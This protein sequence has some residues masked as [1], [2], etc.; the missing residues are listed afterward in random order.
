MA[1]F[2]LLQRSTKGEPLS[3]DL[4]H[5]V[6]T[7]TLFGPDPTATWEAIM[8]STLTEDGLYL[9]FDSNCATCQGISSRVQ[10]SAKGRLVAKPLN[11]PD[12]IDARRE[13]FGDEPPHKPTLMRVRNGD[14]Q[15]WTG[16]SMGWILTKELGTRD[17]LAIIQALGIERQSG[18]RT[19]IRPAVEKKL[20]RRKFGQV[21]AGLA[22]AMSVFA[23]G[24]LT[25]AAFAKVPQK[26]ET[27][28]SCR[29]AKPS[30]C[31]RRL[32]LPRTC[33]ASPLQ[34]LSTGSRAARLPIVTAS[35]SRAGSLRCPIQGRPILEMALSFQ[36]TASSLCFRRS[37]T[38]MG[39][40]AELSQS[41][42]ARLD[43]SHTLPK[44]SAIGMPR[45]LS[46]LKLT[47][48]P[49]E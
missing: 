14:I 2:K 16:P 24:S 46:S 9:A 43:Y 48:N 42:S 21:A 26:L 41:D 13:I 47:R 18:H 33:A 36:E 27:T 12:V 22:A 8:P 17:T 31:S 37:R 3:L 34:A 11:D 15:A 7:A 4:R 32:L 29:I 10:Q 28:S 1:H 19:M 35:Q 49:V 5:I 39:R 40:L 30:C 38:R 23:T 25:S 44:R 45:G 6:S 20:S